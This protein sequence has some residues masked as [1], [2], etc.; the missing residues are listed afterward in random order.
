LVFIDDYNTERPHQSLDYKT[1]DEVYRIGCF[2]EKEDG[3]SEEGVA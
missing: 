3:K 2:P 1:P